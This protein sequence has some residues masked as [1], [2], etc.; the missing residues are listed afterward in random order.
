MEDLI[1]YE[2]RRALDGME[3]VPNSERRLVVF[4][5][6]GLDD[7]CATLYLLGNRAEYDFIDIMPVGGNVS[8][9]VAMRNIR[10]L[11]CAAK[12]SGI[13]LDGVRIVDSTEQYQKY[14][15]LPS[16]HGQ[17][18][19]GDLLPDVN[20]GAVPEVNYRDW[21]QDIGEG[22]RILSLGPCTM[23][24]EVLA[25]AK[26]LPGGR[27]LVMGGC[28]NEVPNYEGREFNEGLDLAAFRAVIR[29]PHGLA[30]LDT[31]RI[32]E[33]NLAGSRKTGGALFDQFVNRSIELAEARHPDNC[34]I[35]D[36]I[37]AFALLHPE[38]FEEKKV[39][40]PAVLRDINLLSL[41]EEYRNGKVLI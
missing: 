30:A 23:V 15:V 18:G 14:C 40:V 37:A 22:Y 10:K 7:A 6:Y 39:N 24:Q 9:R 19:M 36:Y 20:I 34:Y 3:S 12:D 32:P 31:C 26:N 33:F 11:L 28:I 29:R 35:Y 2:R 38:L 4:A 17:D 21:M 8:A 25:G 16:I 27:I 13:S 1:S 41:K 5:D